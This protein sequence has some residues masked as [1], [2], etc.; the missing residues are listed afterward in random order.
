MCLLLN[1]TSLNLWCLPMTT[2]K[3]DTGALNGW[4]NKYLE[5]NG[6]EQCKFPKRS[7]ALVMISWLLP[8]RHGLR[9]LTHHGPFSLPP[10]S[11]PSFSQCTFYWYLHILY[12]L[13]L[14]NHN[15]IIPSFHF[16]FLL[17]ID[18][19]LLLAHFKTGYLQSFPI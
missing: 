11:S 10:T 7:T 8:F 4:H 13:H 3:P 2:P 19:I 6:R 1:K 16:L 18:C 15:V 14:W 17:I 9:T 12:G 5:M